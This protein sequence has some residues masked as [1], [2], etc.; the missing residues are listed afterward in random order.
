MVVV[1]WVYAL[2]LCACSYTYLVYLLIRF[3]TQQNWFS[4]SLVDFQHFSTKSIFLYLCCS[5]NSSYYK[6]NYLDQSDSSTRNHSDRF[7]S[8]TFKRL[9]LLLQNETN[10]SFEQSQMDYSV[11]YSSS[12]TN[13]DNS[14]RSS[15]SKT[16]SDTIVQNNNPTLTYD[17]TEKLLTMVQR[18]RNWEI[19]V[20]FAFLLSF[21]AL[22]FFLFCSILFLYDVI[23]HY[24]FIK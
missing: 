13:H 21:S 7:E 10:E 20:F 3:S 24:P 18:L 23:Y 17:D 12:S 9:Q 8:N 2:H 15:S 5:V 22:F 1:A 6:N 19:K 11:K 4:L 14:H 16:K